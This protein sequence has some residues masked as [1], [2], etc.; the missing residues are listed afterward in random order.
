MGPKEKCKW[1]WSVFIAATFEYDTP[2]IVHIQNKKVGVLYRLFQLCIMGFMIGL[3]RLSFVRALLL[4]YIGYS[5]I[6]VCA[7]VWCMCTCVGC[8]FVRVCVR[9][10]AYVCVCVCARTVLLRDRYSIIYSKGYQDTQTVIGAVTTKLKGVQYYNATGGVPFLQNC[11]A[12]NGPLVL[13]P[14]D[15]VIPPEVHV[16]TA[17]ILLLHHDPICSNQTAFSS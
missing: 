11:V 9:A 5:V 16:V 12:T 6:L 14:A 8:I 4:F 3:V 15:Y 7:Y 1:A 17:K 2:K 10:R 13:D